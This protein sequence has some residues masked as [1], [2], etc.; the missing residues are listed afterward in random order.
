MW[1]VCGSTTAWLTLHVLV[2]VLIWCVR[3]CHANELQPT[4]AQQQPVLLDLL[5]DHT[6]SLQVQC[7][8]G[9]ILALLSYWIISQNQWRHLLYSSN[10]QHWLLE[11]W[12]WCHNNEYHRKTRLLM[13]LYK[14]NVW[15]CLVTADLKILSC[16]VVVPQLTCCQRTICQSCTC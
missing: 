10:R 16:K 6:L 2:T 3:N 7:N 8:A 15:H 1:M 5:R 12:W 4:V 14:E 11:T 9:L 13:E